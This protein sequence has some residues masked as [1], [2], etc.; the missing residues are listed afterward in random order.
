MATGMLWGSIVDRNGSEYYTLVT[1][2]YRA[3]A[4]EM[5]LLVQLYQKRVN[6]NNECVVG[7]E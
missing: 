4:I 6:N 3:Y 2:K 7:D 5:A 1:C